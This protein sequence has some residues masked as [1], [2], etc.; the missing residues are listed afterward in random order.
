MVSE[1]GD[2]EEV[3]GGAEFKHNSGLSQI[4]LLWRGAYK[5]SFGACA[6]SQCRWCGCRTNDSWEDP[7]G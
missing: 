4:A 6:H 1:D 2:A 7:V 3:L 5:G